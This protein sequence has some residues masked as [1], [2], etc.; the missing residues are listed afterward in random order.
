MAAKMAG[1]LCPPPSL[2]PLSL[3]PL[4]RSV[5]L[6]A[7]S[8][9]SAAA[10]SPSRRGWALWVQVCGAPEWV[11][12]LG[13]LTSDAA[14][15]GL[16]SPLRGS[17]GAVTRPQTQPPPRA[18]S[19]AGSLPCA[20]LPGWHPAWIP[21][22]QGAPRRV[23]LSP[24]LPSARGSGLPPAGPGQAPAVRPVEGSFLPTRFLLML[25]LLLKSGMKR[26]RVREGIQ[27]SLSYRENY[28]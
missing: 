13:P 27:P 18:D 1:R 5:Y 25:S 16:R 14:W 24:C 19:R 17:S 3:H 9:P 26:G 28:P 2:S 22:C 15:R 20:G 6:S 7:R 11:S 4:P 8:A 12:A 10:E 21:G 23:R